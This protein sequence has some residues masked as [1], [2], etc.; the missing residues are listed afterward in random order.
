MSFFFFF[1]VHHSPLIMAFVADVTRPHARGCQSTRWVFPSFFSSSQK[2]QMRTAEG[3]PSVLG[4]FFFNSNPGRISII[5]ENGIKLI[6]S[7]VENLS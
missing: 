1:L 6:Y 4:P 3:F 7:G 5:K 2:R